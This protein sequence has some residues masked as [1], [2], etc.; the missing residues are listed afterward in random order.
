VQTY[1]S[2][3]ETETYMKDQVVEDPIARVSFPRF[4]AATTLEWQGQ[5]PSTSSGRRHVASSLRRTRLPSDSTRR[6]MTGPTLG[7]QEGPGCR[8][9]TPRRAEVRPRRCRLVRRGQA[10]DG[11]LFRPN[12]KEA[13]MKT[14]MAVVAL[15]VGMGVYAAVPAAAAEEKAAEKEGG[16]AARIQD[17]NLTDEQEAKIA[18]IRKEYRPK[19]QEA[20]KELAAIVKEE[21]EK[22]RA[23]LTPEQK[24]KLAEAKEERQ[25]RKAEG[26]SE[27]IAHLGELDLT[28][29]EIAK[30]EEI[31]KEYRPKIEKALKEMRGL[32]T[33]E[34]KK[35]RQEALTAGKKRREVLEALK[36]TDE[37]KEKVQAVAKEVTAIVREEM[38][39]IRDVLSAE[40]KEKLQDLKE[41]TKERVRDRMA[42]RIANL[43][44]LD[45]TEDQKTQIADI[46]KE[47]R[48]KVHEAGNKMRAT[49][50]EE[51][52]AIVAVIKG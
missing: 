13:V 26:Q 23:V 5:T 41:E 51:V 17:L 47:Y 4:A 50:R 37:Q 20:G 18:D 3:G 39:K 34:Q 22:I 6:Q 27:R 31:R 43:K 32:L 38:E 2:M 48:P 25:A 49:I 44:G 1:F 10:A 19:V 14:L 11:A 45:L 42:H 52:E 40:Q 30:M 33:D 9:L 21:V 46:R 16:L 7:G 15:A 35:A 12:P 28:D 29:G 8:P 24:T 36:L